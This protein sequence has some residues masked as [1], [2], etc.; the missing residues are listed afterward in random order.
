VGRYPSYAEAEE[1]LPKI[2]KA[3]AGAFIIPS[4]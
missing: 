2:H 1:A 4:D 3:S